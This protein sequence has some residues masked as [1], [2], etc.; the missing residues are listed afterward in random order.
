MNKVTQTF[1]IK[2]FDV[3]SKS[4]TLFLFCFQIYFFSVVQCTSF[5][6]VQF[7]TSAQ[8]MALSLGAKTRRTFIISEVM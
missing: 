8:P 3:S 4:D 1:N 6:Y 2:G 7:S 5:H